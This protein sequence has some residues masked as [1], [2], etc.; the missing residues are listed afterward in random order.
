MP[1]APGDRR[2]AWIPVGIAAS[3][4]FVLL[5]AA[6][7]GWGGLPFDAPA[8]LAVQGLPVPDAAWQLVTELGGGVLGPI[9]FG[10]GLW[11]LAT[12]RLRL[13]LIVAAVL[14]GAALFV[15]VAKVVVTR[16]RPPGGEL[17]ETGYSFPSGHSLNSAATY[18]LLAVVAWRTERLPLLVRR[19]AVVAALLL[20][21]AIGL[22]R[23][24]LGVHYPSDVLGGWSG[25]LALVAAGALLI[26]ALGAMSW[27]RPGVPDR[28]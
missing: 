14:V 15:D 17:L 23:V 3:A 13:V 22:S 27:T 2:E 9:G 18:G 11:A 7:A 10:L 26:A 24:A 28:L 21:F 1:A 25:G 6:V 12:G 20:P 8:T 16:P 4:A 5:G 19:L